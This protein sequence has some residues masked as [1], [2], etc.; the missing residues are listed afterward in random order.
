[1]LDESKKLLKERNKHI[2]LAEK[3]AW[4]AMDFYNPGAPCMWLGWWDM[5]QASTE[6]KQSVKIGE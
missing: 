3:F 4:E 6:R 2:M 1:M 5:H